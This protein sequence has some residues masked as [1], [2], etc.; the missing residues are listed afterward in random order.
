M[1]SGGFESQLEYR[2]EIQPA[3]TCLHVPPVASDVKN[4]NKGQAGKLLHVLLKCLCTLARGER[5]TRLF[6]CI[7]HKT[8]PVISN[9]LL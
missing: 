1:A 7:A 2:V 5:W 8:E 3:W 6:P 4:I 9:G